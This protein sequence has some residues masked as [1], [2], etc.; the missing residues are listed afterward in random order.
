[1][2]KV[3]KDESHLCMWVFVCAQVLTSSFLNSL[4]FANV[5]SQQVSSEDLPLLCSLYNIIMMYDSGN[6]WKSPTTLRGSK[7]AQMLY[8]KFILPFNCT[9]SWRQLNNT[10]PGLHHLGHWSK[11]NQA[12]K[13]SPPSPSVLHHVRAPVNAVHHLKSPWDILINATGFK[14]SPG[15]HGEKRRGD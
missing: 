15:M 2:K 1:M 14:W 3:L 12:F 4:A 13:P 8:K 9:S 10:Y 7:D 6:W 11:L 5:L